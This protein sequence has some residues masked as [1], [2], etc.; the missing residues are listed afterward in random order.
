MS[1]D[2]NYKISILSDYKR[3]DDVLRLTH[4]SLVEIGA[5][6]PKPTGMFNFFPHLDRIENTTV[7]IA[8]NNGKIIGTNSFTIDGKHG[9]HT[10]ILFKN[11]T[12]YF[13]ESSQIPIASSWR[14]ATHN[15]YRNKRRL[16]IDLIETTRRLLVEAKIDTCLCTFQEK[17]EN[18][19][20]RLLKAKTIAKKKGTADNTDTATFVLMKFKLLK[21]K[22]LSCV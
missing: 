5:I 21:S 9:L 22:P 11:E 1:N 16:I 12:N 14:I 4:D 20:K 18:V 6:V 13:R 19:Y 17:H 8:E 2:N 3:L 10:D 15:A 7:L